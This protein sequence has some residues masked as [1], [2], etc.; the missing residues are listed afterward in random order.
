MGALIADVD[1]TTGGQS[2]C[3]KFSVGGYP[4]IKYEDPGDVKDYEGGRSYEDFK[5]FASENLGPTCGPGEDLALC[6]AATKKKVEGFAAMPIDKLE[7]KIKKATNDFEVQIP[8]M[9]KVVGYL[10]SKKT[11]L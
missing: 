2:L 11:D 3:E 8:I 1:C 5:K 7:D 4:T 10:K 9:K 6:D